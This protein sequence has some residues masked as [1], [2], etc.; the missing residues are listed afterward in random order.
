MHG[1]GLARYTQTPL[2]WSASLFCPLGFARCQKTDFPSNVGR[3]RPAVL[4]SK[5]LLPFC[6]IFIPF[7]SSPMQHNR[8]LLFQHC[9]VHHH[10]KILVCLVCIPRICP[11]PYCLFKHLFYACKTTGFLCRTLPQAETTIRSDDQQRV[12]RK[13]HKTKRHYVL[14]RVKKVVPYI[15]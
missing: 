9:L 13:C 7:S 14:R 8:Y 4:C 3:C 11:K 5:D 2:L 15:L 6:N 1:V 12:A 10:K